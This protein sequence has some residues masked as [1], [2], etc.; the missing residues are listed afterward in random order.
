MSAPLLQGWFT[1]DAQP[2]LLGARCR[3]CGSYYFPK[4]AVAFCRNPDCAGET[5]EPV[6]L[7]RSGKLWS[8]TNAAYAPP[9]P[10]VLPQDGAFVPFAI[11]A[12]ELEKEKMIVLGQVAAGIGVEALRVG[13]AMELVVEPLADGRLAW[14]WKP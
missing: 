5:F 9:E 8:Y 11:A 13:Q 1:T 10:Y 6:P 3:A 12:V 2:H 7:S 4:P 14:K